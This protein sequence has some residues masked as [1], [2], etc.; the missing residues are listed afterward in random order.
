MKN[1]ESNRKEYLSNYKK[2]RLTTKDGIWSGNGKSYPHILPK[3]SK[4]LNILDSVRTNFWKYFDSSNIK[5]HPDF[6]HLNSSQALCFNLFFPLCQD[7]STDLTFALL[8]IIEANPP[9]QIPNSK[10]EQILEIR[11]DR[12]ANKRANELDEEFLLK[13]KEVNWEFEKILDLK[14]ETN[15]DFYAELPENY[16]VLIE[17][18][19]T[20]A[21][22][23]PV[24]AN[25]TRLKKYCEIYEPKLRNIIKPEFLNEDIIFKY[26]QI[27]RYLS[28]VDERTTVVFLFPEQND[29]LKA[30][31][32]FIN[33]IVYGN[34]LN[35]VRIIYLEHFIEQ[36]LNS[37]DLLCKR[38]I[39]EEF[40]KK[41][42]G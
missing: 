16:Q 3:T 9:I 5:L 36:L 8:R 34:K 1:Y 37:E 42:L 2:D 10:F 38:E 4:H 20:E 19:Y 13:N 18:K 41:Y 35:H 29:K 24:K 23:G 11:D 28:Y 40:K 31:E 7:N 32:D 21:D 30:T 33:S 25:K 6:H 12:I 27:A 26:Y 15:I 14:E 17:L 22:F 39:F